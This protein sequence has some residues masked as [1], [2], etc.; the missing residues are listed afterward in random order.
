MKRFFQ[1]HFKFT[2]ACSLYEGSTEM[3][4]MLNNHEKVFVFMA[5]DLK[6]VFFP[7]LRFPLTIFVFLYLNNCIFVFVSYLKTGLFS[8]GP[9]IPT[10]DC[11]TA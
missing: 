4:D 8:S 10:P 6:S 7:S 5:S 11:L 9:L 3:S 2:L 1:K